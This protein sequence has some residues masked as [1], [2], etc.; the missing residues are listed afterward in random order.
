[1]TTVVTQLDGAYDPYAAFDILQCD[2][3]EHLWEYDMQLSCAEGTR[4]CECKYT[5]ELISAGLL[6]CSEASSCPSE[7][8]I[9]SSCMRNVCVGVP[10]RVIAVSIENNATTLT[11]LAF[12]GTICFAACFA[13]A[14]RKKKHGG[15]LD[16]S[17]MEDDN[18]DDS[19]SSMSRSGQVWLV[20]VN[21]DGLPTENSP[22]LKQVWLAPADITENQYVK[23]SIFPDLLKDT[24]NNNK[25]QNTQSN[26][27]FHRP[28]ATASMKKTRID[29]KKKKK[30]ASFS[31][32]VRGTKDS[33][34]ERLR[35]GLWVP[36]PNSE[37][38]VTSSLSHST[39]SDDSS[40]S[41]DGVA[42]NNSRSRDANLRPD[43]RSIGST[44][45]EI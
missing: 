36:A 42:S 23:D 31:T 22:T 12:F 4:Y 13:L 39:A 25:Q 8:P 10:S 45:G 32:K 37:I 38:S 14:R 2:T 21:E 5:E 34:D 28:K 3:Y 30:V 44:E 27:K 26:S 16:E 35:P 18:T 20:P 24:S 43:N 29:R 1:M 9:C 6:S 17:L 7:C 19:T 41:Y 33:T 15:R 40:T 11:G